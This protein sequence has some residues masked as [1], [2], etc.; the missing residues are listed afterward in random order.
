MDLSFFSTANFLDSTISGIP[1]NQIISDY[2]IPLSD[3]TMYRPLDQDKLKST[4]TEVHYLSYYTKCCLLYTSPS[5]RDQ[6]G[7][8][9]PS[10]A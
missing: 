2:D 8:R 4:G 5:P 9:M 1:V 7:S 6:R 10:S 3:L